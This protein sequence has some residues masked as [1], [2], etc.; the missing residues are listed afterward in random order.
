[1]VLKHKQFRHSRPQIYVKTAAAL[2]LAL[3]LLFAHNW[4]QGP[5]DSYAIAAAAA[6][7]RAFFLAPDWLTDCIY[8][9]AVSNMQLLATC[10]C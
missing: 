2:A 1:M 5:L 6:C 4:C 8:L 9:L 10:S 7:M 3:E